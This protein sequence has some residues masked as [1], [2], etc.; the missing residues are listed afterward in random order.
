M[1]KL[2]KALFAALALFL[3]PGSAPQAATAPQK[4]DTAKTVQA[5]PG[6][7]IAV[8]PGMSG[9][10]LWL[11]QDSSLPLIALH[12]LL[13]AGSAYDPI[14]KSG[15]AALSARLLSSG[16]LLPPALA[17]R[18]T[19]APDVRFSATANRDDLDISLEVTPKDAAEVFRILGR[20]LAS[21]KLNQNGLNTA[22]LDQRQD[23][24][25]RGQTPALQA[26]DQL[27]SLYYGTH[28][29]G[30]PVMGSPAGLSAIRQ[31][32]VL[33]F[34]RT[35]WVR[36]RAIIA[37]AGDVDPETAKSLTAEVFSDLPATNV[38]AIPTPRFTGAPGLH[39]IVMPIRQPAA[40]AALPGLRRRDRNQ[41]TAEMT[42]FILGGHQMSRL[43]KSLRDNH[44]LTDAAHAE[45]LPG[46]AAGLAVTEL[47]SNPRDMREALSRLRQDLRKFA[48]QGPSSQE[49]ST[50]KSYFLNSEALNYAS[51]A[52]AAR[53]M[54]MR[55]AAGWS[56]AD[57]RGYRQ[58]VQNLSLKSIRQMAQRL[59]R[60]EDI[61]I[62][63]LGPLPRATRSSNPYRK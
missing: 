17:D 23:M 48:L 1:A 46:N 16:A 19:D 14:D 33:A 56:I 44:Q 47:Q 51:D 2:P 35:H 27:Y 42:A 57:M 43:N 49:F 12:I 62:V 22:R 60:S 21:P 54:A 5:A 11:R 40:I 6:Q 20:A 61:T 30:H 53:T 36:G 32:D 7:V 18:L 13:P 8:D 25:A 38:P 28:G 31:K 45:M 52:A 3:M 9:T 63:V 37:L 34:T 15:L 26:R 50:A 41:L 58:R 24:E 55:M 39:H 10:Q 4:T 59:Y 29:Y